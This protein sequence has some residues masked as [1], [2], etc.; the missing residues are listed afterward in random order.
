MEPTTTQNP[1]GFTPAE[2]PLALLV[3]AA[4]GLLGVLVC[5][6]LLGP[7]PWYVWLAGGLGVPLVFLFVVA[8]A[9]QFMERRK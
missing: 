7:I 9:A 8:V 4:F 3:V 5:R 1:R 6:L 2:L